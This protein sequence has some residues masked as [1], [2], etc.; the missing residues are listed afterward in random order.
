MKEADNMKVLYEIHNE[1]AEFYQNYLQSTNAETARQYLR[2]R[3]IMKETIQEFSIGASSSCWDDLYRHLTEKGFSHDDLLESGLIGKNKNGKYYDRFRSRIMFPICDV[4]GRVI[5]FTGRLYEDVEG[6]P[7]YLNSP[8]T[9][10]FKKRETL[11]GFHLL[12]QWRQNVVILVEGT[13][14]VIALRQAGFCNAVAPLGTALTVEQMAI[15]A[16]HTKDL[17]VCFDGDEAGETATRRVLEMAT[18]AGLNVRAVTLP[19]WCDPMEFIQ[20]YGAGAFSDLLVAS[21]TPLAYELSAAEKAYIIQN[22]ENLIQFLQ[23]SAKILAKSESRV[24]VDYFAGSIA[25][26]YGVSK[27]AM[28]EEIKRYRRRFAKGDNDNEK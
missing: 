21:Q 23:T 3:Q 14:D 2:G 15:L 4:T 27:D 16:Q 6:G 17:I 9:A 8:E 12:E 24:A 18:D 22:D 25:G 26:K 11:Y 19:Q 1:A 10:I 13:L 5:G 7:K 28:I 20:K